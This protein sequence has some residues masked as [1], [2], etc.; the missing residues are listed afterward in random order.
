MTDLISRWDSRF[1]EVAKLFA[2]FS[3]DPSTKVGACI[4]DR[5]NR[6]ASAAFNGLPQRVEDSD[7]RLHNRKIKYSIT[8]HAEINAILLASRPVIGCT[9]YVWPFPPCAACASVI[10]QS[11]LARVVAPSPSS[12]LAERW[13]E[14]IELA[15]MTLREAGVQIN[16]LDLEG[17]L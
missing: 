7:E 13:G 1:L 5:H 14:S 9:I 10:I 12:Q 6:L 11:G 16:I 17:I 2:S 4:A 15:I 8:I 3:K